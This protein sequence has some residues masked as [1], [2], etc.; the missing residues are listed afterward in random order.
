MEQKLGRMPAMIVTILAAV[1]AYFLRLNQLQ[2]MYDETGRV[3]AGTG[4]GFFTWFCVAVVLLFAAYAFL[5]RP[6]KKQQALSGRGTGLLLITMAGAVGMVLG[7]AA[8]VLDMEQEYDVLLAAGG[9]VAALC[10]AVV[11]LERYRGRKLPAALFMIPALFFAVRL[12]M[13]FRLWSQDPQILDYCFDLF[14]LLSIMCATYYLG[15]FCFDQGKRRIAVFCCCCAIFFGASSIAGG[16][17][18]EVA[19]T[20]GSMLWLTA[21]LWT[22]LRPARKRPEDRTSAETT[23][24]EN[25]L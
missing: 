21:N 3:I 7:C 16:R 24:K 4:K 11:G 2:H 1:A 8:M 5:L 18:R 25:N 23:E 22:L 12:I 15:G 13:D 14:A 6:R 19:M 10:W 17:L 9:I 20:G